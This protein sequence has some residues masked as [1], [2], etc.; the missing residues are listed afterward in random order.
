MQQHLIKLSDD[1]LLSMRTL[2]LFRGIVHSTYIHIGISIGIWGA[3]RTCSEARPG[4]SGLP[5][6]F[7]RVCLDE[8]N[9]NINDF[10]SKTQFQN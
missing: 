4:L 9:R 6:M 1:R 10:T 5:S 3:E 2:T 8:T 7:H